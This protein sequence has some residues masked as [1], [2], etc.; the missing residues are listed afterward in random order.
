MLDPSLTDDLRFN[1]FRIAC[2]AHL[3]P[4]ESNS[5]FSS[6]D[7]SAFVPPPASETSKPSKSFDWVHERKRIFEKMS[8]GLLASFDRPTP[9]S[10]HPKVDHIDQEGPGKDHPEDKNSEENPWP[11]ELPKPTEAE[12]QEDKESLAESDK[13]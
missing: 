6:F 10:K 13:K 2:T 1:Q 12:K 7:G 4:H 11:M 9:G 8:P 3:I 5:A